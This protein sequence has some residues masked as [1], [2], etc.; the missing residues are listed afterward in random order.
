MRLRGTLGEG[1]RCEAISTRGHRSPALSRAVGGIAQ[2][3]EIRG[4][5]AACVEVQA[6]LAIAE[7]ALSDL[8]GADSSAEIL[9]PPPLPPVLT[10]HVSSIPPY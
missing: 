8:T 7:R 5:G 2:D 9:S 6:R 3:V 10:G 4:L 1:G